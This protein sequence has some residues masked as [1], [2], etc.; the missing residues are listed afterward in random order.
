LSIPR[1][2]W[3]SPEGL[4]KTTNVLRLDGRSRG[5]H[6]NLII[7]FLFSITEKEREGETVGKTLRNILKSLLNARF[8]QAVSEEQKIDTVGVPGE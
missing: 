5:K 2:S 4:R 3:N 8:E 6:S 1:Y 7:P